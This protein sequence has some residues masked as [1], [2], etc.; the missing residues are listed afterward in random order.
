SPAAERRAPVDPGGGP[1]T[2]DTASSSPAA[3]TTAT[4]APAEGIHMPS[5]SYYP[6]VATIG[7]PIIGY[8]VILTG[9]ASWVLI[10]VGAFI[11]IAGLFG[12]A[13]EPSAEE[14]H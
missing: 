1:I 11:T 5:P 2:A 8:G 3:D 10:G 14:H 9:V 13:I 4:H 7:I 12:W 6:L